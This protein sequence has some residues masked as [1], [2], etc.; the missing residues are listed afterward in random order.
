MEDMGTMMIP[1]CINDMLMYELKFGPGKTGL[2]CPDQMGA[3]ASHRW[4]HN[5]IGR[6]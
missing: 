6:L 1:K 3:R 5:F 4:L 2:F